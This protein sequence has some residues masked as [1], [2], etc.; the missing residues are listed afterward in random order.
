MEQDL[1]WKDFFSGFDFTYA[2]YL[3]EKRRRRMHWIKGMRL[4]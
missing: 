4:F 2:T 1:S 3:A